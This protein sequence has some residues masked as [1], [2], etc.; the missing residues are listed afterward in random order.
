M[1]FVVLSQLRRKRRDTF[2]VLIVLDCVEREGIT[3]LKLNKC[4]RKNPAYAWNQTLD[5][6]IRS[7]ALYPYAT[8]MP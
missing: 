6:S 3:R 8:P 1:I 5:L 2:I 4:E 7:R